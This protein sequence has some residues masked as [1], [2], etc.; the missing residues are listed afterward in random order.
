M[1]LENN[2]VKKF[3]K[4]SFNLHYFLALVLTV[5]LNVT[6]IFHKGFDY[7]SR[8]ST[9]QGDFHPMHKLSGSVWLP[10]LQF[11][12]STAPNPR[13]KKKKKNYLETAHCKDVDGGNKSLKQYFSLHLT[14]LSWALTIFYHKI[15]GKKAKRKLWSILTLT[16]WE[17]QADTKVLL[18]SM[19]FCFFQVCVFNSLKDCFCFYCL[20]PIFFLTNAFLM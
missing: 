13:G 18:L 19:H 11:L 16:T 6:K 9:L 17:W 1:F 12:L 4:I 2:L 10:L 14:W 20:I 15:L 3:L 5:L 7:V 8:N